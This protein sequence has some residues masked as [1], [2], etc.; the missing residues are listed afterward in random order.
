M[1]LL[2]KMANTQVIFNSTQTLKINNNNNDIF[3][4][5]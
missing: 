5:R 4:S 1:N 3:R 2:M